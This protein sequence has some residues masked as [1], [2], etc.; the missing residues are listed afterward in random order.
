MTVPFFDIKQNVRC[1]GIL[2]VLI[3]A[4]RHVVFVVCVLIHKQAYLNKFRTVFHETLCQYQ[5]LS[6]LH[7]S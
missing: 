7:Y 1:H 2:L 4:I 6:A 3:Y 5:E